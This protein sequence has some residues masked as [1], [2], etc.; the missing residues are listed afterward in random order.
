MG[1]LSKIHDS[2]AGEV[3]EVVE[4]YVNWSISVQLKLADGVACH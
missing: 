3:A 4:S 1:L 2:V